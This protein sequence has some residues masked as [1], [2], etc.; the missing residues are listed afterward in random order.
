MQV[1]QRYLGIPECDQEGREVVSYCQAWE[2]EDKEKSATLRS[3]EILI[4]VMNSIMLF[5]KFTLEIG[6]QFEDQKLPT[7]DL[8]C[9][10]KNGIIEFQFF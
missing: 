7:L 10:V 8:K 6:E 5:L 3:S 9:W 2:D 1:C 4:G